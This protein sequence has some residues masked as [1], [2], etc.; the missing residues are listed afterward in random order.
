MPFR[1]TNILVIFQAY[2]NYTLSDLLDKLCVVY[3]DN[4]FFIIKTTPSI[5]S[6]YV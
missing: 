5:R 1:F 6:I 3:L 4:I 2:I